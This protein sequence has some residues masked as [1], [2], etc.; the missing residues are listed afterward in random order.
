MSINA[1]NKF[2]DTIRNHILLSFSSGAIDVIRDNLNRKPLVVEGANGSIG[3][4]LAVILKSLEIEPDPLYITTNSSEPN[5]YWKEFSNLK[6][7]KL[8]SD[9]KN[10]RNTISELKNLNVF[11]SAGYGQP[12][13][14]SLD[15]IGIIDTNINQLIFYKSIEKGNNFAYMSTSE[16]YSGVTG[17]PKEDSPV[18][19][20]PQQARGVY[21]ESKRLGEAITHNI[22]HNFRR[23]ASYRVALAFPIKH[24]LEDTR[25]LADLVKKAIKNK[26]VHISN[27]AEYVRQYQYAPF[28]V[29]K[30]LG[31]LFQ[32][33]YDLYNCGGE[34]T[35]TIGELGKKISEIFNV[36]FSQEI[37][38]ISD[39][40]P[41]SVLIDSDLINKD[42]GFIELSM[43]IEKALSLYID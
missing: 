15:P 8:R 32:G 30:I 12:A 21:I 36:P 26:K 7:F 16:I 22:L 20:K 40:A 31:S 17:S 43:Y 10:F 33:E 35:L 9:L 27:G 3:T 28:T 6:P 29:T 39:G 24:D 42:S 25:L 23:R 18:I 4:A 1:K 13:K 5:D 41:S 14:F 34:Y 37:K 38:N 2:I 11:Y 19:S